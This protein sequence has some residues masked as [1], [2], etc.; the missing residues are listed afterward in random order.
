[1]LILVATQPV[2]IISGTGHQLIAG[3]T[4]D[5]DR[6]HWRNQQKNPADGRGNL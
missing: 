1:M 2:T 5:F 3:Y 4:I 6:N